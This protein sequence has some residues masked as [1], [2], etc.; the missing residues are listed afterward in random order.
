M[1][2]VSKVYTIGNLVQSFSDVYINIPAPSSIVTATADL[3][4]L[5]LDALGQPSATSTGFHLGS[6]E[7]PT[8]I[9]IMEK[10]NEIMDDQ[11]ESAIDVGF[12]SVTAEIDF[13]MKEQN[14]SRLSTLI[15]SNGLNAENSVTGAY[16]ANVLQ[17][18]GQ[19]SNSNYTPFTILLVAPDRKTA[20]KFW[21]VQTYKSYLKAAI[22]VSFQRTKESQFK[23]KFGCV[24]DPT[25][26]PGDELMSIVR[27][28]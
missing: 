21:Y 25:R 14:L 1:A 27:T 28:K 15:A 7:G 20:G 10:T 12:V 16:S 26:V 23:L 3:S 4:T 13:V 6:I 9:S 24:M 2:T 18:G 19:L 22:D 5:T 17:Y 11:H 8:N